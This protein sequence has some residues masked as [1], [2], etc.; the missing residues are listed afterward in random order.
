[1]PTTYISLSMAHSAGQIWEARGGGG[2]G[3][4]GLVSSIV[5]K[6]KSRFEKN[7]NNIMKMGVVQG[8]A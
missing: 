7:N 4:G 5:L 1:M 2:G 6:I 3:G 8:V